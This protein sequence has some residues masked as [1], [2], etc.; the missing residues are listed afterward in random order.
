MERRDYLTAV[1]T[2]LG[3]TAGCISPEDTTMT[4]EEA[5]SKFDDVQEFDNPSHNYADTVRFVDE[6]A[7]VVLYAMSASG[8][9][10]GRGV[11]LT[12][13]PLEETDL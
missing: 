13:I 1:A 3:A 9:F 4:E 10:N 5:K 7:G 11:G 12:S 8:N 2:V 6:D